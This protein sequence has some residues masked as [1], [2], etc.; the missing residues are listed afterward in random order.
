MI[1]WPIREAETSASHLAQEKHMYPD[2]LEEIRRAAEG[3]N[4]LHRYYSGV[5]DRDNDF[6]F[7]IGLIHQLAPDSPLCRQ[8][9]HVVRAFLSAIKPVIVEIT[10]ADVYVVSFQDERL[11][12]ASTEIWSVNDDRV[13][14]EFVWSLY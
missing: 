2:T 1:G 6:Y 10:L 3:F 4:I 9:E 14:A 7:R 8:A 11:P 13:T 12:L 5:K